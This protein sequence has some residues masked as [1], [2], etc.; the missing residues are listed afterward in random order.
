VEEDIAFSQL[1]TWTD[2]A[3]TVHK[4]QTWYKQKQMRGGQRKELHVNPSKVQAVT[5]F[6]RAILVVRHEGDVAVHVFLQRAGISRHCLED[7]IELGYE[8]AEEARCDDEEQHA[9]NLHSCR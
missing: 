9:V 2:S 5:V 6:T 8:R 4:N 7:I 1:Q 3:Q